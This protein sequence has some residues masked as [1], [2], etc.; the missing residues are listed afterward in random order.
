M[1]IF[2]LCS[3]DGPFLKGPECRIS[4]HLAV[5]FQIATSWKP[6]TSPF[7][8]W[9]RAYGGCETQEKCE[10]VLVACSVLK[11]GNATLWKR[12]RSLSQYK[13]LILTPKFHRARHVCVTS[14]TSDGADCC[15]SKQCNSIWQVLSLFRKYSSRVSPLCSAEDTSVFLREDASICTG[16]RKQNRKSGTGTK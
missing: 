12:T 9:R 14:V 4:W 10:S 7:Q 3:K 8:A 2:I 11:H 1:S 13:E 15:H 5:R 16:Q 6:L